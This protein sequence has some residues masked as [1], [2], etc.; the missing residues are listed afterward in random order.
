MAACDQVAAI[1]SGNPVSPSQQTINT[2]L[3]P[4]LARSEL[5]AQS[6]ANT[7]DGLAGSKPD[8]NGVQPQLQSHNDSRWT[9]TVSNFEPV[10]ETRG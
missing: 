6:G 9:S 3:M 5:A 8:M 10:T 1:A 2:S 7:P 4:R